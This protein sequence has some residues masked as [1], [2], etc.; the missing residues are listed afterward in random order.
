[1]TAKTESTLSKHI[2]GIIPT[3]KVIT[4]IEILPHASLLPV[5]NGF[6]NIQRSVVECAYAGCNTIWIVCEESYAP[7]IKKLCGDFVIN[8]NDY[9]RSKHSKHPSI[10]RRVIPIFY[11]P[12]SY[13]YQDKEGL[14]VSFID[15]V[16][17]SF[18]VSKTLSSWIVPHKYYVSIPYGVY[19]PEVKR[20]FVKS[21]ESFFLSHN[22]RTALDGENLGF[23]LGVE[24][25]K[26]CSYLYKKNKSNSL[27]TLDK[28]IDND[29]VRKNITTSEIDIYHNIQ[30]WQ[31]YMD[32]WKN[33]VP[34]YPKYKFCFSSAFKMQERKLA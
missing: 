7:L 13:K 28:I 15:G 11:T 34:M 3:A 12:L 6:Y 18:H 25:V 20:S 17:A 14:G 24:E 32:M 27:F 9:E 5:S 16:N 1:M 21:K 2:A 10:N 22:G 26:H 23:C 8:M 19:D 33:I 31:G 29:I 4:D 30:N